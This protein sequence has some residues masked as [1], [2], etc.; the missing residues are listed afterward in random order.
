M[1]LLGLFLACVGLFVYDVH[2]T[3]HDSAAGGMAVMFVALSAG[4]PWIAPAFS[5]AF[6]TLSY[7]MML[8][9]LFG[10]WLLAGIGYISLT[11]FELTCAAVIFGW[12]IVFIRQVAAYKKA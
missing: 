10:Y 1:V 5:R 3:I 7:A 11:M 2:P 4:L 8:A 12:I 6:F 9:I